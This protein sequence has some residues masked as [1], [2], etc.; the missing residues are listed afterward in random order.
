MHI[1]PVV[2]WSDSPRDLLPYY[3]LFVALLTV[4][5]AQVV[6]L[7]KIEYEFNRFL[8]G[9]NKR[10]RWANQR[11]ANLSWNNSVRAFCEQNDLKIILHK[12]LAYPTTLADALAQYV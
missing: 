7:V 3:T 12:R 9:D 10:G 8:L 1:G 5:T 4:L 11:L 2:P 6:I